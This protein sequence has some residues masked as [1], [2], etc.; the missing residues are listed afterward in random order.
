M[1]TWAVILFTWLAPGVILFAWLYRI[2][3]RAAAVPDT[4]VNDDPRA[5]AVVRADSSAD[6]IETPI[7]IASGRKSEG[8]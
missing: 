6:Q 4:S 2:S 5:P 1:I 7:R 3:R 8:K